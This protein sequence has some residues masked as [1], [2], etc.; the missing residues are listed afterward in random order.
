M[1]IKFH[2]TFHVTELPGSAEREDISAVLPG[3]QGLLLGGPV[4]TANTVP[5]RPKEVPVY[6]PAMGLAQ[7]RTLPLFIPFS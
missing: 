3:A 2:R 5:T 4:Y 1:P 7:G 6:G